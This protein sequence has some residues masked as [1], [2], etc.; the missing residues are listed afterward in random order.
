VWL[1]WVNS[2]VSVSRLEYPDS[3]VWGSNLDWENYSGLE[4]DDSISELQA[5]YFL[6]E[7]AEFLRNLMGDPNFCFSGFGPNCTANYNTSSP[8]VSSP[9]QYITNMV[10]I[11]TNPDSSSKFPPLEVQLAEGLGK[12]KQNP[13]SFDQY[14]DYNNAFYSRQPFSGAEINCTEAG[15]VDI[16][17]F[18]FTAIGFGQ[19][20]TSKDWALNECV[21][22]HELG[23]AL[24]AQFIPDIS[25]Y[26]WAA[27][28]LRSDP[29]AMNEAWADYFAAIHCGISDFTKTFNT[30]PKRN[31]ENSLT[32]AAAV[33]EVHSDG[34]IFVGAI[35]KIRSHILS[36]PSLSTAEDQRRFDKV[37]LQSLSLG[38]AEDLFADQFNSILSLLSKDL[39]LSVLIPFAEKEF[40]EREFAC[41]REYLFEESSDPT[42]TLPENVLTSVNLSTIP[43]QIKFMPRT[44]DWSVSVKWRQFAN[45]GRLGKLDIGFAQ[46]PMQLLISPCPIFMERINSDTSQ[47]EA[48]S[49]CTVLGTKT[50]LKFVQ[51]IYSS[52]YGSISFPIYPNSKTMFMVIASD[53]PTNMV[54]YSSSLTFYGFNHVWRVTFVVLGGINVAFVIALLLCCRKTKNRKQNYFLGLCFLLEVISGLLA[55]FGILFGSVRS[56]FTVAMISISFISIP[57]VTW[58]FLKSDII[59][60]WNLE[61]HNW[62]NMYLNGNS[63]RWIFLFETMR[64]GILVVSMVLILSY[65]SPIW[66]HLL[67]YSVYLGLTAIHFYLSLLLILYSCKADELSHSIEL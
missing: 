56:Y 19:S 36:T 27:S 26:T 35:W 66:V 6:S 18:Q 37:I 49:N 32:C 46:Q 60:Q 9:M 65:F 50:K 54:L 16:N 42:F 12:T 43:S 57:L 39:K 30:H 48:F 10:S 22:Y 3:D 41:V 51:S 67:F 28:G 45:D 63:P 61:P 33:G 40:T 1:A 14:S 62:I 34:L 64:A 55:L 44:S 47:I 13:I 29:G 52:L 8:E 58:S 21:A 31:L 25:S 11:E 5:F 53:L 24:V 2:P 59:D 17:S 38:H 23:H 15:C 20:S 7:H 4:P